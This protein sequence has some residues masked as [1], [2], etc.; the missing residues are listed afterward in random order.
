M[1]EHEAANADS[2]ALGVDK[3]TKKKVRPSCADYYNQHMGYVDQADA[4]IHRY[5]PLRKNAKWT[6]VGFIFLL[7]LCI[8]N[9]WVLI[10]H[11]LGTF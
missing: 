7:K 5:R 2:D 4:A 1:A 9:A 3:N 10:N 8:N 6:M 11:H